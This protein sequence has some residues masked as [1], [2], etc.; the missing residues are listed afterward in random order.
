MIFFSA[1][2]Q[3]SHQPPHRRCA[4]RRASE[5]LQ[6]APPLRCGRRRS[7]REVCRKQLLLPLADLPGPS[8]RFPRSQRASLAFDLAKRFTEERL[9]PKRLAASL[10]GVPRLRAS[11][12]F[13][14]RSSE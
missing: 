7:I 1:M 14:L 4:H 5:M 9:T 6:I 3:P 11:T 12:I 2:A 13:R 8:R 10:L